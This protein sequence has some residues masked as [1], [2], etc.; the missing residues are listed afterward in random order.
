[1]LPLFK[2]Y[3]HICRSNEA[4]DDVN[5]NFD[6]KANSQDFES[7]IDDANLSVDS[8]VELSN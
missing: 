6:F 1:M 7:S 8:S 4:K 3:C 5:D 2:Y